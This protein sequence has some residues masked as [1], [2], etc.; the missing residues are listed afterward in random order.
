MNAIHLHPWIVHIMFAS[1]LF[2]LLHYRRNQKHSPPLPLTILAFNG[3]LATTWNYWKLTHAFVW[4][5]QSWG[6]VCRHRFAQRATHNR[7]VHWLYRVCVRSFEFSPHTNSRV[8]N[9]ADCM[10]IRFCKTTHVWQCVAF[11]QVG[12]LFA[13]MQWHS[14]WAHFLHT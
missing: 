5:F 12:P 3:I 7:C 11:W 13:E 1:I 14:S 10:Q 9:I 2:C 8:G 6:S 4:E